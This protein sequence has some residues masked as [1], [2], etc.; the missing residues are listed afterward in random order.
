[1]E[2][3]PEMLALEKTFENLANFLNLVAN[4]GS[5]LSKK[6]LLI[7]FRELPD[8]QLVLKHLYNPY[9]TTGIKDRSLDDAYWNVIGVVEHIPFNTVYNMIAYLQEN[10]TGTDYALENAALLLHWAE[11]ISN[12]CAWLM[13]GIITKNLQIG[14][15]AQTLNQLYGKGFIPIVGIMRGMHAPTNFM[16]TYIAT[17]KIDGNRRVIM[18]KE[19]GVEI[20]TRSG[21]RDMGLTELEEQVAKYLP[22]GYVYDTECVA[23][24]TFEDNVALR[25]ASAA[26]LNSSGTRTGVVAKVFDMMTQ[27][28]YDEGDNTKCA[29]LRKAN[30]AAL[31]NDVDGLRKLQHAGLM[32]NSMCV[33]L[34]SSMPA[35]D[36]TKCTAIIGLPILG[37][38]HNMS[39][40][41]ALAQP[42]WDRSGEGLMLVESNSSYEVNPNPRKTLL[43]IKATEESVVQVVG[44]VEGT[45]SNMNRLGAVTVK[46]TGKDKKEYTF[47]V[48]SGFTQWERDTYWSEP[49]LII[50]KMIEVEHF[51][52][53]LNKN[54]T[55]ALNCPI[56]KRIVGDEER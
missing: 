35:V 10:N 52:E 45:N 1:M 9:V 39:E 55:R 5:T 16:G 2:Q 48:G 53:S 20:Y 33:S 14:V 28:E 27:E 8:L 46:F 12:K 43:K 11:Q 31:F 6:S 40:A 25:Q 42:V 26:L 44:V 24:G 18:N 36:P 49:D 37:I 34:M 41:L 47:N 3:T 56:F 22:V 38:V 19:S 30:I 7:R 32:N 17:E 29:V 54:G 51:G 15:K 4:T 23:A 50:G 21:R 13:R